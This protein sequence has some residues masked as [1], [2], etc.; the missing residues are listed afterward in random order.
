V[1]NGTLELFTEIAS[2]NGSYKGYVKPLIHHLDV[3]GAEDRH[4]SALEKIWESTV[5]AVTTLIK[6]QRKDQLATKVPF[7]G[8]FKPHIHIGYAILETLVNAFIHALK[9]SLDYE[10]NIGSVE[11][12]SAK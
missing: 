3:V 12:S 11:E 6:N 2:K 10:I 1:N 7:E 5:C 8:S 9:P 4:E